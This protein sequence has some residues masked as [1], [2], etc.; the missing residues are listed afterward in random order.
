MT[1]PSPDRRSMPIDEP[2]STKTAELSEINRDAELND[3]DE[4]IAKA[5]E[6]LNDYQLE[7]IISRSE[8]INSGNNGLIYK[9]NLE[10]MDEEARKNGKLME[11]IGRDK[12]DLSKSDKVIKILKIYKKGQGLHEYEM[13]KKAYDAVSSAPNKKELA[14]IPRPISFKELNI[15]DQT[16]EDLNKKGASL[17]DDKMEIIVMDFVPGTDLATI[18]YQWVIDNHS[19]QQLNPG[20]HQSIEEMQQTVA[21]LLGFERPGG[22]GAN[23]GDRNLEERKVYGSNA[24]KLYGFLKKSGFK[25]NPAVTDQVKNTLDLLHR[26]GIYHNDPHERNIVISNP[27]AYL[28][29]FG[30]AASEKIDGRVDDGY[31]VNRLRE[32][33]DS[34]KDTRQ[35]QALDSLE[36]KIG[37]LKQSEAW[38]LRCETL[39][40]QVQENGTTVLESEFSRA[41]SGEDK[42]EEFIAAFLELSKRDKIIKD[43]ITNFINEKIKPIPLQTGRKKQPQQTLPPWVLNKLRLYKPLFD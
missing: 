17:S 32:L 33:T 31:L 41:L 16:Q 1:R 2:E 5:I 8:L 20:S 42:L 34:P 12:N 43:K 19:N 35:K 23:D 6:F 14:R 3:E 30:S 37:R 39:A 7:R 22:K 29:D 9:I 10:I 18:I 38:I 4:E 13:Q 27:Y 36:S 21:M 40:Q 25:I 24:D 28:I 15:S 11:R 26:N